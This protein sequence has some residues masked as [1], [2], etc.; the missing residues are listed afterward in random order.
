MRFKWIRRG[1]IDEDRWIG[2][3]IKIGEEREEYRVEIWR[4]ENMVR[5]EKV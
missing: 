2:E 4:E 3:D 5:R 1:R